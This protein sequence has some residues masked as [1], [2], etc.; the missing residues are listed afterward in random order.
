MKG[1]FV[2]VRPGGRTTVWGVIPAK[3]GMGAE[4]GRGRYCLTRPS[5]L[6]C[7]GL[8]HELADVARQAFARLRE[9]LHVAY[10]FGARGRV[11]VLVSL[12]A[13][14][15]DADRAFVQL[16]GDDAGMAVQIAVAVHAQAR[17]IGRPRNT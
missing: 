5:E 14:E 2:C 11:G 7:V 13:D 16:V 8:V 6:A 3:A 10:V 4:E 17:F 12:A 9:D 15:A 1:A